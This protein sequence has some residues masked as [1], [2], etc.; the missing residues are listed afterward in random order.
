MAGGQRITLEGG[1]EITDQLSEQELDKKLSWLY[2]VSDHGKQFL[3]PNIRKQIVT[4]IKEALPELA[5]EAGYKSP[6]ESVI[7]PQARVERIFKEIEEGWLNEIQR[8]SPE[9]RALKK[10]EG[11]K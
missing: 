5:K 11:V 7:Y 3:S 2:E 8:N 10:Q 4:L 1:S 9:W 6:E